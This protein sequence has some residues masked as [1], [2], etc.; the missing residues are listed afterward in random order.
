MQAFL[1]AEW[2]HGDCHSS[3]LVVILDE[4]DY[5]PLRDHS[6][7]IRPGIPKVCTTVIITNDIIVEGDETFTLTLEEPTGGLRNGITINPNN[8]GTIIKII[9][10]DC[11]CSLV[12][13]CNNLIFLFKC[14]QIASH[15]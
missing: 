2:L 13:D 7:L 12:L 14:L 3:Q 10:D 11:K 6:I 15:F 9:N 1:R 8:N 4:S 5:T